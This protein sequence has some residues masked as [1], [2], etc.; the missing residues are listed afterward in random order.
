MHLKK[1]LLTSLLAIVS[2]AT[3]GAARAQAVATAQINGRVTDP[4]G[5]V[6]PGA[7]VRLTQTDTK[8]IV[9]ARSND[10]GE[11]VLNGLPIGRCVL[12][13]DA[14]GF[15]RYELSGIEL[16]VGDN[17]QIN[18]TLV[19]GQATE[20]VNV[21]TTVSGVDTTDNS[22]HQ[23][24]AQERIVEM[25]LNGRQ[26][27]QLVLL[28]GAAVTAPAPGP[29]ADINTSK[30]YPSSTT[31]SIAG[32]QANGTNYLLDGGDNNDPMTNVNLPFPFP[33]AL[34]EFS[35]DTST[36]PAQYGLH[37]GGVVN[38]VTRSGSNQFHG[39]LFEYVR[40]YAVNAKNHFTAP[41][42]RGGDILKRNQFGGDVGGPV[43]RNRLFFF[44]G[45]QG[46]RNRQSPSATSFIPTAAALQGDFTALES[47]T[48]VA[49][50]GRTLTN[51]NTGTSYQPTN[52][53]NASTFN[54]QAVA[55]VSKYLPATTDP[56]GKVQYG[57]PAT[58]D[59]D[60]VVG[61]VDS[62]FGKQTLF[63]RYFLSDFRNPA[64]FINNNILT[65]TRAGI[66]ARSQSFTL[67][68]TFT[69]TPSTLNS[70]HVTVARLRNNRGPAP[71][72][73]SPNAVGINIYD[74][75]PIYMQLAVGTGGSSFAAGCG[76]CAPAHINRDELQVADDVTL[77]RGSHSM[78]FGVDYIRAR[79]NSL[80][81]ADGNGNFIFN[82]Q[83]TNDPIAD[84]LLG[85]LSNYNQSRPSP[86][87]YRANFIGFYGQDT[88]RIT[89]SLTLNIGLRWEPYLPA[90]DID[91]LGVVFDHAAYTNNKVSS[92]YPNAPPGVFYYGDPGVPHALTHAYL[93]NLSPRIGIIFVPGA[94]A[95]DTFRAGFALLTDTPELYFA[96]HTVS[97]PP[98]GNSIYLTSPAGGFTN[99][100]GGYAGGNPFPIAFPPAKTVQFPQ[101]GQYIAFGPGSLQ[102]TTV[103]QW[104]A[105]YEHQF[106]NKLLFKATYLGNETSHI[107]GA[108][109]LNPAQYIPGTCGSSPCS[110]TANTNQRRI[111]NTQNPNAANKFG[112][113]EM[114]SS[115]G[116]ASYH[117]L[118]VS[119][120]RRLSN[121]FSVLMNYTY[122]HCISDLDF[123]GD[124]YIPLYEI[125]F[126]RPADRGS[127]P[128]DVRHLFNTSIV[129]RSPKIGNSLVS[130]VVSDWQ[131]APL[132]H[133]QSGFPINIVTG[134]DNSRSGQGLDRPNRVLANPYPANKGPAL[135]LNP[136]AFSPNAIGTFG[137]LGR[138]AAKGPGFFQFD[139]SVNRIFPI[140][141]RFHA[142]IRLDV[143]NV[144]NWT[145]YNNPNTTLSSSSFGKITSAGDPRILQLAG[146]FHF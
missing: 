1:L 114:L 18:P 131:I 74:Y 91:G 56:C 35:V 14:T 72:F 137:N 127:C 39:D 25:P 113:V 66:L 109:E 17:I 65:T 45:Y 84:F 58:G 5:A 98:F 145:N 51:P 142:E 20:V 27:T 43:L 86:T 49:G 111:L 92:V 120:E 128:Q 41:N 117:A 60:Q 34:Q 82:G 119:G 23:V 2:L 6:I 105:G 103:A 33:E 79:L 96:E 61:R 9:E 143:F 97:S 136:A 24:I 67:G 37:P 55:F 138:N 36:L 59:E 42:T 57:I 94:E 62:T 87:D 104:N 132:V 122:S 100:W 3:P 101:F 93:P 16:Q 133:Y 19:L 29:S 129:A 10:Q 28:S 130:K 69:F 95:R 46:T 7:V 70:L 77:V 141:E 26:A 125:P 139:A 12:S 140:K 53:I 71:N 126:N 146:K 13:V 48:C 50:G 81:P 64:V 21:S 110:T 8:R 68:H 99:P 47:A 63:G 83:F 11:F 30:N 144:L 52:H 116:V 54:P 88:Y 89:H 124:P 115:G 106:R 85:D 80:T 102:P 112:D 40:N 108:D 31:I 78:S 22:V 32:G 15:K 75:L 90:N 121:G 107:L 44:G 76:S 135:W 38:I 4:T 118:L 134:T 73:P 123:A